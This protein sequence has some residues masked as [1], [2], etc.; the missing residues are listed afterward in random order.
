[1]SKLFR[2]STFWLSNW[3][4]TRLRFLT[5]D[6][7]QQFFNQLNVVKINLVVKRLLNQKT[8]VLECTYLF[9][10]KIQIKI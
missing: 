10:S 6:W 4:T 5:F 7:L 1:M 8:Q 9:E 2:I 3:I